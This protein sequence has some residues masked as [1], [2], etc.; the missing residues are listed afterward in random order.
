MKKIDGLVSVKKEQGSRRGVPLKTVTMIE[1]GAGVVMIALL[2]LLYVLYTDR[3]AGLKPQKPTY[4]YLGAQKIEFSG[5][6][7][8]RNRDKVTVSD[9]L[10]S[11]DVLKT[12]LISEEDGTLIL[13]CNMLLMVPE[14]GTGLK[15]INCFTSVSEKAGRITYERNDK[16][17]QSFG[18]FLY[19][20]EDVYIFLEPTTLIIG[21]T[22]YELGA[23]SYAR[24]VY[25]QQVEF[26]D[27]NSKDD[28]VIGLAGV[29]VIADCA[30]GYS[31]NLGQ[32]VIYRGGEEALLFSA[33][34]NI[35]VIKM[36]R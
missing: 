28:K 1:I 11:S 22:S 2:L 7:D 13:T 33:V 19:D 5:N 17:A 34:D 24:V 36:G 23:L 20:G 8:F 3:L 29:S 35:D 12:P 31:L 16:T 14:E 21:N 15:R 9:G 30:S 18:G 4:Q 26:F 10:A 6:A 27:S 25:N 32:D